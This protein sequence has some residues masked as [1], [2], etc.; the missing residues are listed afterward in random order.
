MNNIAQELKE[1]AIILELSTT[2]QFGDANV[3][4]RD[5]LEVV[6]I[7]SSGRLTVQ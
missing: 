1:F 7:D 5:R 4:I 3:T 2:D 6:L